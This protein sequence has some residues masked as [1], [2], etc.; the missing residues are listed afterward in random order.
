M[1]VYKETGNVSLFNEFLLCSV[2][3]ECSTHSMTDKGIHSNHRRHSLCRSRTQFQQ[4]TISGMV[5]A[6]ER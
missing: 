4:E 3:W 5:S 1:L 6:G 2:Q